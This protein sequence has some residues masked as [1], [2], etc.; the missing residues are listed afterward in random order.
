MTLEREETD[1][2]TLEEVKILLDGVELFT[3]QDFSYSEKQSKDILKG[4]GRKKGFGRV[5]GAKEYEFSF[6]VKR[7]NMAL[8][9]PPEDFQANKGT[10]ESF[11][12]NGVEYIS[13]LDLRNVTLTALYPD[14]EGTRRKVTLIGSEFSEHSA[15]LALSD[16]E[17]ADLSGNCIEIKGMI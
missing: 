11:F 8:L 14:Q 10:V 2:I 16:A 12:L 7:V 6:S 13:L 3:V 17:G 15:K 5:R 1:G 9:M 4:A